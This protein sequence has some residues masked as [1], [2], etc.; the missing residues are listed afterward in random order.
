MWYN[1]PSI[2]PA[3]NLK[4]KENR[5]VSNTPFPLV[6]VVQAVVWRWFDFQAGKYAERLSLINSRGVLS[7]AV[8][9]TSRTEAP[10]SDNHS[11]KPTKKSEYISPASQLAPGGWSKE[12]DSELLQLV[13]NGSSYKAAAKALGTGRSKE[14]V[15][16]RYKKLSA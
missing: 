5:V 14:S 15:S 8:Q 10:Q 6:A 11:Q 1:H 3:F 13:R 9:Q 7:S 4:A 16:K 12:E 2:R